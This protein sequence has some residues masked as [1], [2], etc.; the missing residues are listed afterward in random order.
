[1]M[2]R[3]LHIATGLLVNGGRLTIPAFGSRLEVCDPR[4]SEPRH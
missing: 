1:M 2:R 4:L 3:W